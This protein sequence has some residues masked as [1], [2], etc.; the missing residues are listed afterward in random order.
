MTPY[1]C[2]RRPDAQWTSRCWAQDTSSVACGSKQLAHTCMAALLQASAASPGRITPAAATHTDLHKTP[3]GWLGSVGGCF[4]A[5]LL[6]TPHHHVWIL[7]QSADLPHSHLPIPDVMVYWATS[8]LDCT[9][10]LRCQECSTWDETPGLLEDL[11]SPTKV[12]T[13]LPSCA[14]LVTTPGVFPTALQA[15]TCQHKMIRRAVARPARTHSYLVPL[16]PFCRCMQQHCHKWTN[17]A[18]AV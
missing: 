10:L 1:P 16:L 8:L 6:R 7:L 15:N 3:A 18:T 5:P 12:N 11:G 9:Q 13:G 17:K 2:Q 14:H 4:H